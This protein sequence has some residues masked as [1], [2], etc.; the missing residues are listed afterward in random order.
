MKIYF[1]CEL[2]FDNPLEFRTLIKNATL[3]KS[4]VYLWYNNITNHFYIG[5]SINLNNRLRRYY[6]NIY[7]T[8][9]THVNLPISRSILKYI[10]NNFTL[11]I[12]KFTEKADVHAMEQKFIDE[13]NPVY[14]V[15]KTVGQIYKGSIKRNPMSE[16]QRVNY[17]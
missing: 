4:G 17:L 3:D 8:Y 14:N 15:N 16:G 13:L 9:P 11:F 2:R 10:L 5:S 6:Q 7:L 1:T 12:L